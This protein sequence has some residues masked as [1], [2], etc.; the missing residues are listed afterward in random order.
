MAYTVGAKSIYYDIMYV[1]GDHSY[2][3]F[4][5]IPLKLDEDGEPILTW[6]HN[7][8]WLLYQNCV[9]KSLE[10]GTFTHSSIT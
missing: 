7:I 4:E 10:R 5:S 6:R 2:A 9:G 8:L 3:K 1:L